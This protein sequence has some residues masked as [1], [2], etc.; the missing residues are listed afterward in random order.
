MLRNHAII[1]LTMI[2]L[3]LSGAAAGAG[4]AAGQRTQVSVLTLREEN[5]AYV[6]DFA[7]IVEGAQSVQIR[8]Q[9]DGILKARH[10][11]EGA[12]VEKGAL[13]FEIDDAEYATQVEM[14]EARLRQAE[15]SFANAAQEQ[16]RA[17]TLKEKNSISP[18]EYDSAVTQHALAGAA[19]AEAR[20]RLSG[21]RLRLDKTKIRAP[22][23]G[24][25]DMAL[26]QNGSLIA[27]SSPTDSLL[28]KLTNTR[29][30]RVLFHVPGVRVRAINRL[31]NEGKAVVRDLIPAEL[32][33]DAGAR[34][35]HEGRLVFGSGATNPRTGTMTAW[36]EFPNPDGELSAG[37]IVRIR[38]SILEF[39]NALML[40]QAAVQQG[41][42]GPFVAL[43][44]EG[45]T[46][47][48]APV[49][50][51]GPYGSDFLLTPSEQV[52]AGSRVIIEGANKV[53]GGMPVEAKPYDASR[54]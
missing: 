23:S 33:E 49:V 19:L 1:L 16:R 35:A 43:V 34:Y 52:K 39:T 15:A 10:Y 9:V 30:V 36:A 46:A 22:I 54:R 2:F 4:K 8:A 50:V 12:W 5:F 42:D 45:G 25:A 14:A 38:L 20:A 41:A 32:F 48:F 40:P 28:T 53:R 47:A 3:A 18:K 27:A 6:Q 37:Q 29:E 7:G 24:Y 17:N 26:I 51:T 31:I 11:R 44:T 13:L 21:A